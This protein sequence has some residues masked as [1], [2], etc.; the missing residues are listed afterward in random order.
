VS[1]AARDAAG[2]A[3]AVA[4][5][6]S[7]TT[8]APQQ[9]PPPTGLFATPFQTV[10]YFG[11]LRAGDS[12]RLAFDDGLTFDVDA[13]SGAADW[14]GRMTGVPNALTSLQVLYS[15]SASAACDQLVGLYNWT[16]GY[17]VRIDVRSVGPT[18]AG[19]SLFP[20]GT[21]AD[22]VSG[23]TGDGDVAVRIRCT[24]NDGGSFFTSGDLMKLVWTR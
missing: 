14:Y 18:K 12:S 24:R 23:T 1:T 21:L 5:T 3:L 8:L 19:V 2:N 20:T 17:W 7:F 6:W 22:F 16:Y 13:T 9:P 10:V 11:S 4:K 15:G